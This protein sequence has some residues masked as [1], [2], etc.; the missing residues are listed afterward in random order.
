MKLILKSSSAAQKWKDVKT[1]YDE[2]KRLDVTLPPAIIELL[3][4]LK[5]LPLEYWSE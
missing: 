2:A 5:P 3:F 1:F 4:A